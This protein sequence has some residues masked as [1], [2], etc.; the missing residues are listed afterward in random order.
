[1]RALF[2]IVCLFAATLAAPFEKR[3]LGGL[4]VTVEAIPEEV[5]V[6]GL[7][8]NI[9]RASGA[10]VAQLAQRLQVRWRTEGSVVHAQQMDG[11]NIASRLDQGRN[12][13][14]Q[15]RGEGERAELLHSFLVIDRQ[16][17]GRARA[18]FALPR[19]CAW[20]RVIEG[21]SGG[22]AFEQH[23]AHC[24]TPAQA[25]T[26]ALQPRLQGLGWSIRRRSDAVWELQRSSDHAQ[27]A[28][29]D[30]PA[31]GSSLVWLRVHAGDHR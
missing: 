16:P 26:A 20:G 10:G 7:A 12:E 14:L 17:R 15:W 27:L 21:V 11:W 3:D 18:P 6:D 24:E 8:V 30:G 22:S 28:L 9:T 4:A 5:I 13:L 31:R 1:M 23:A 25:L 19:A 2:I 29:I